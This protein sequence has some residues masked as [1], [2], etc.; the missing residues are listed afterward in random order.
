MAML[1][2]LAYVS[3]PYRD[4]RGVRYV[5]ENIRK[6]EAV[7]VEL[8]RMG[9]PAICPHANTRHFDGII[10]PEDFIEGDLVMVSR[11]DLIVMMEGWEKSEGAKVELEHAMRL[12][13]RVAYWPKDWEA[14]RIEAERLARF[15]D[16]MKSLL[17]LF[18]NEKAS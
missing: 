6:A 15:N 9:I 14:L 11:C 7:A 3:G 13:I 16:R 18:R 1:K 5:E 4:K 12:G 17:D 10:P 8:W 2:T